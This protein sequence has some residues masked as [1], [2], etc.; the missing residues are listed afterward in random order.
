MIV[1]PDIENYLEKLSPLA[2]PIL[3][4]MQRLAAERNFPII[5]P[6]VGRFLVS[7]IQFGHVHTVL[8]CGSGFGYSALWMATALSENA[9]I[10][11]IEYDPANIELAKNFFKKAGLSHKA[12]FLQGNALDIVPTLSQ[13]YDL[14]LNDVD[15]EQYPSLLPL[16]LPRLRTGGILITDNVLWKGKVTREPQDVPTRA[17][18]Q[19]TEALM[20]QKDLWNSIIPIRDGLSISIKLRV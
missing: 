10:T 20:Q 12:T 15:K 3:E 17:I 18:Q 16:L 13:T 19:Y 4:E 6:V 8:E 2:H 5:G 7:L 11:C 14:V 9:N 1:H